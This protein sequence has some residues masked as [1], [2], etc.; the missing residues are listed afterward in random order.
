MRTTDVDY[1]TESSQQPKVMDPITFILFYFIL[2]SIWGIPGNASGSYFNH[3]FID[4][5]VEIQSRDDVT[6]LK[7]HS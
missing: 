4:E 3:C 2:Y 5:E 1:L 7:S 6:G